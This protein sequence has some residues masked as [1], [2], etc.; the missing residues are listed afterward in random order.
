MSDHKAFTEMDMRIEHAERQVLEGIRN[1]LFKRDEAGNYDGPEYLI[2]RRPVQR[3]DSIDEFRS[4]SSVY[5]RGRIEIWVVQ[6]PTEEFKNLCLWPNAKPNIL[7]WPGTMRH[8]VDFRY[9]MDWAS[10]EEMN[11][12]IAENQIKPAYSQA[13]EDDERAARGEV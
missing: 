1:L 13:K 8:C 5:M 9:F 4:P 6:M 10:I 12:Y 2:V 7:M 11:E 3:K